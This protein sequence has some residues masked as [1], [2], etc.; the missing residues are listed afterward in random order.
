MFFWKKEIKDISTVK[1]DR[2]SS[3]PIKKTLP[4]TIWEIFDK[5]I[6]NKGMDQATSEKLIIVQQGLIK[7]QMETIN[8]QQ[9]ILDLYIKK[10]L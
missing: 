3:T 8:M 10:N 5:K 9:K 4:K 7:N 2:V 6:A 1:Q